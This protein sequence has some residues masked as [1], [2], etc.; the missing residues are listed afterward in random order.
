MVVEAGLLLTFTCSP[1]ALLLL[2]EPAPSNPNTAKVG[3]VG[4]TT[5][6]T[7]KCPK[8]F[9][10]NRGHV[11]FVIYCTAWVIL[12]SKHVREMND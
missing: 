11:H 5:T 8:T 12:V 1:P 2:W 4:G 10:E 6:M 9:G 3:W 7:H